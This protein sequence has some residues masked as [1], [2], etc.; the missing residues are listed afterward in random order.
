MTSPNEHT[1]TQLAQW[2]AVDDHLVEPEVSRDEVVRGIKQQALPSN[3]PHAERQTKIGAILWSHIRPGY[4]VMS[5]LLTRVS[6]DSDFATDVCVIREGEDP[7]TGQRFLEDI[8]FEI[9]D[10]QRPGELRARA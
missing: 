4:K 9:V 5:E 2:P 6:D 7:T 3:P 10:T 1:P 8:A